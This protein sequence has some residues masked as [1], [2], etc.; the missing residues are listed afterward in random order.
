[1]H[2]NI[3]FSLILVIIIH[4]IYVNHSFVVVS[5]IACACV[6]WVWTSLDLRLALVFVKEDLLLD[7]NTAARILQLIFA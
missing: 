3:A 2:S 6:N 1:M 4:A 7:R 5:T